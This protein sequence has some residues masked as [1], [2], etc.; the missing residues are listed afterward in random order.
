MANKTY[1][2]KHFDVLKTYGTIKLL[3]Q[4]LLGFGHVQ[5]SELRISA[6]HSYQVCPKPLRNNDLIKQLV[7][8]VCVPAIQ[9]SLVSKKTDFPTRDAFPCRVPNIGQ[10]DVLLS[11]LN[12]ASKLV[13]VGGTTIE[14]SAI[15]GR[16]LFTTIVDVR[17]SCSG[18]NS[19][20]GTMSCAILG[21]DHH[22]KVVETLYL[23]WTVC[24]PVSQPL[25]PNFLDHG[26]AVLNYLKA[27]VLFRKIQRDS[28]FDY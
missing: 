2:D 12:K 6:R 26:E 25:N 1:S 18:S 8:T 14:L 22:T 5:V 15:S 10:S 19:V 21:S 16:S 28:S 11:T 24:L 7:L 4:P 23:R 17:G 9:H 3:Q 27:W 13:E 20:E